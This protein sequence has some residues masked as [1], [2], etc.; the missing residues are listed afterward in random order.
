MQDPLEAMRKVTFGAASLNL[1]PLDFE[2]NSRLIIDA[3]NSAKSKGVSILCLPE[4][5]VSGYGCEDAFLFP[6]IA[7]KSLEYLQRIQGET[8]GIAVVV[9]L[10]LWVRGN[11]FNAA[12]LLVNKRIVGF[13]LKQH[14]ARSGVYY[15]TRWFTPW[16]PGATESVQVGDQEIPCGDL[17]FD[18]DGIRVGFEICEDAW[19]QSRLA[20]GLHERGVD[21]VLNPSASHFQLNKYAKRIEIIKKGSEDAKAIYIYANILGNEAGRLIFDGDCV[22]ADR[23]TV[24][25]EGERF[26][27]EDLVLTYS[28]VE[29]NPK[30]GKGRS[31]KV[32]DFSLTEALSPQSHIPQAI[33]VAV[34]HFEEFTRA[35]CL[36]LFDYMRKSRSKGFTLSLSG[37]ADSGSIAI[38]VYLMQ[39][40]AL[41]KLGEQKIFQKLSYWKNLSELAKS[42][43]LMKAMLGCLYQA[44]ENSSEQTYQAAHD[45][46]K[47]I[48]A[49]FAKISVQELS[50]KY[51]RTLEPVIGRPLDWFNDDLALQNIQARVRSPGI[52]LIANVRGSLLLTTS[53]RSEGAVGYCT[54]D[55]DTS[56]GLAPIAGIDKNFLRHWLDWIATEGV[57]E[58][59]PL[60]F[61]SMVRSLVPTA[62]LRPQAEGQTDEKDLMPYEVLSSIEKLTFLQRSS[63]EQVCSS[64]I[65]EFEGKFPKPLLEGW[66]RKFFELWRISQWKRER[67][68]PSFHLDEFNV[69]PRSWCRFPILS[70]GF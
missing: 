32:P 64:I 49:G 53:N 29:L 30:N 17:V 35:V 36:G 66:V 2:H 6:H 43:G 51:L 15:E 42:E 70:A 23:G 21:I 12:A 18:L 47:N 41:A 27:F 24:I 33:S 3:I 34:P 37:G 69:D 22:I 31:I 10:P 55:G 56:G 5:C 4:L 40:I 14:L 61:A 65:A 45:L 1:I 8:S 38:L 62:E 60:K 59:G 52:W 19:V 16:A 54:M 44:T 68:A 67:L 39:A 63:P 58:S 25:A 57:V 26:S 7:E 9:G 50:D 46:A 13:A 48:G 11:I 28:S 20:S